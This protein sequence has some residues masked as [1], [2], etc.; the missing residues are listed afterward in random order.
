MDKRKNEGRKKEEGATVTEGKV[1]EVGE[2]GEEE[3]YPT[4]SRGTRH[5]RGEFRDR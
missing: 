5:I 4:L 3:R 1:G 2:V